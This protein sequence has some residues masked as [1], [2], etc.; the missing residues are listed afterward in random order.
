MTELA[1]AEQQ[2]RQAGSSVKTANTNISA[3][4]S[5][6]AEAKA[7]MD[8]LALTAVSSGDLA[9]FADEVTNLSRSVMAVTLKQ[10]F[11]QV[12]WVSGFMTMAFMLLDIPR[13]RTGIE[14]IPY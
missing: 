6:K 5:A 1:R 14:K 12:V 11:G 8:N 9:N 7:N 10:I 13:V 4:E 2:S 3:T